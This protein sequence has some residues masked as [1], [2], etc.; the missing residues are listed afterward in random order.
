[1]PLRRI[2]EGVYYVGAL[3]WDRRM[4]DEMIPLPQG[5]SYNSYF[6]QGTEKNALI[7]TV[8]PEKTSE[9]LNNLHELDLKIDYIVANHAEQDHSGSIPILLDE[10]PD[11][12]VVTNPKCKEL[13]KNFL[14]IADDKFKTIEDRET[15]SL[16]DKN[17]EFIYTPWVHW[18]DTMVTYLSPYKI[19][20]SCDF[21]GSHIANSELYAHKIDEI[22]SAAKKYYAEIMMP[23]RSMIKKN[24]LKLSEVD[25]NMIAPSH[26]PLYSSPQDILDSYQ[27]WTS[28]ETSNLV[29]IPYVS[30]H[31]ST[32][33]MVEFLVNS[34]IK[35]GLNV[36]PYNLAQMDLGDFLSSLV[37]ASTLVIASPTVL[38]GPHPLT[39]SNSYLINILRPK[40]KYV[41]IIG[42]FGWGSRMEDIIKAEL[43]NLKVEYLESISIKGLPSKEDL[44]KIDYLADQILEKHS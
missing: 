38:T 10:Y 23:F 13:L 4:F 16:G 41:A 18:P 11:S 17:L 34:L 35:K 19:L 44:D 36:K 12:L 30:M 6:I 9:L 26:G 5:T 32:K 25:I 31:G 39:V 20:F 27:E 3:D 22:H 7:D 29:V 8:D 37:D 43:S 28:D 2:K 14:F 42:S 21:F 1:M 40:L 24:L 15:L 33:T